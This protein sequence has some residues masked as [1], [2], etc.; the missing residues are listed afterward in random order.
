MKLFKILSIATAVFFTQQLYAQKPVTQFNGFGHL[1]YSLDYLDHADS[2][3]SVGEHDFFISSKLKEKISF[4]GEYVIRFNGNSATSY[5]PSIERTFVK[6]NYYK[7][8]NIIA[9]KVHSPVNYWN[10]VYH[11]GRL[12]FPTIDRP[13]SFSYLVPLHTLGIQFQG[14]NLG[15]SNFGYDILLGNGISSSDF[16]DDNVNPS[17]TAAFHFKP[18]DGMRIGASYYYDFLENNKSGI[19][20][21]HSAPKTH[22]TG[23]L[24]TGAVNYHLMSLS[25]A[26]FGN[27][28]EMLNEFS[29]NATDTD[30]LGVANNY[31]NFLYAGLRIKEKHVPYILADYMK[32]S[33]NDLHTYPYE[34]HKYAIGYK[35]EF[36]HLLNVK[37]QLE[38]VKF[39]KDHTTHTMTSKYGF[40]IQLAYGF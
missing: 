27:D 24:Y 15:E 6:F 19:H 1:E 20:S 36:S 39:M 10:D 13:I 33:S 7:N 28:F 12:F 16:F 32:I 8:H 23:K 38:Y 14:Q 9:G 37:T 26:Y 21:G 5:L 3:F 18:V 29:Y 34:F 17:L 35:Y 2:Y 40:R 31:S 30:T 11:H 25:Y 22:Y 4:L